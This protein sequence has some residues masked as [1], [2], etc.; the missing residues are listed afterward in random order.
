[1]IL[2]TKDG[3]YSKSITNNLF[4]KNNSTAHFCKPH[5]RNVILFF[6]FEVGHRVADKQAFR[7]IH[8]KCSDTS[9]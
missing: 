8:A 2:K 9:I 4:K 3:V 6:H 7:K 1:M 5:Q